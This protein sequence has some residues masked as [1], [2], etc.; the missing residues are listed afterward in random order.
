MICLDFYILVPNKLKV[1]KILKKAKVDVKHCLSGNGTT[2]PE[3]CHL[4]VF[5]LHQNADKNGKHYTWENK[6]LSKTC[7]LRV[8]ELITYQISKT[9]QNNLYGGTE[10]YQNG[11]FECFRA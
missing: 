10:H 4:G 6:T 3:T 2:L 9:L 8:F 7:L 5:F 11:C 1:L